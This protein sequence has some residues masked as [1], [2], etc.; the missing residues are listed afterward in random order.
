MTDPSVERAEKPGQCGY[1]DREC[2]AGSFG[3]IGKQPQFDIIFTEACRRRSGSSY[4]D[5][6]D[7]AAGILEVQRMLDRQDVVPGMIAAIQT[8]GQLV[9]WNPHLHCLVTCGSFTPDGD[10]LELP[11]LEAICSRHYSH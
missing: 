11:E 7:V 6:S 4:L 3:Y 8:F 5:A 9:Q 10:F 1:V 2:S